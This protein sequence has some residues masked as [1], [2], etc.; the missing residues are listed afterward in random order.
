[1]SLNKSNQLLEEF[2]CL[3]REKRCNKYEG[4]LKVGVDLGTANI[5]LSVV[6]EN[7][8]PIAGAT[9]GSSVVKD[10]IVVDYMG[11]IRIVKMLKEQVEEI[12]GEKLSYAD[13]KSTRLNSSHC[14]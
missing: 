14:D 4:K 7:N 6:D 10:G 1:M 11:A 13:R 9:Y 3:I 5:V 8:N 2:S 12:I